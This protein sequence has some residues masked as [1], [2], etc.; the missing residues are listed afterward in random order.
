MAVSTKSTALFVKM[1]FFAPL[2][3]IITAGVSFIGD[4]EPSET[5]DIANLIAESNSEILRAGL[6]IR[7]FQIISYSLRW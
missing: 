4:F 6:E 2:R 7:P 5:K 1:R 3:M